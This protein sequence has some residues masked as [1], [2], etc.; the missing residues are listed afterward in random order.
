MAVASGCCGHFAAPSLVCSPPHCGYHEQQVRTSHLRPDC[1]LN[2]LVPS[3]PLAA[4]GVDRTRPSLFVPVPDLIHRFLIAPLLLRTVAQCNLLAW[5]EQ[6]STKSIT[7]RITRHTRSKKALWRPDLL[8]R[9]S[10]FLPTKTW[11]EGGTDAF[12][13]LAQLRKDSTWLCLR[14]CFSRSTKP[15]SA[16]TVRLLISQ[17][18]PTWANLR[19]GRE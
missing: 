10:P 9:D 14:A 6:S 2:A 19:S 17:A 15:R 1:G 13:P 11:P 18:G 7:G 16:G 4:V 3:P 5:R 8:C 12:L